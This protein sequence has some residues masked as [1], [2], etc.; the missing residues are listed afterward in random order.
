MHVHVS[1]TKHMWRRSSSL[2]PALKSIL[3]TSHFAHPADQMETQINYSLVLSVRIHKLC[4]SRISIPWCPQTAQDMAL[5]LACVLQEHTHP[6][7]LT[8]IRGER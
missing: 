1:L 4:I 8:A 6:S 3:P 2:K 7:Y 5:W